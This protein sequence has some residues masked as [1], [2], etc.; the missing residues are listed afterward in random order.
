MR[1]MCCRGTWCRLQIHLVPPSQL[2]RAGSLR[3]RQAMPSQLRRAGSRTPHTRKARCP[4]GSCC[5]RR[6]SLQDPSDVSVTP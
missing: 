4:L 6:C 3:T 5:W 2:R 1:R